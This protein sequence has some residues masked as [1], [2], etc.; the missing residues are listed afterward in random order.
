MLILQQVDNIIQFHLE[1]MENWLSN[2]FFWNA[3]SICSFYFETIS[4]NC[5]LD[6]HTWISEPSALTTKFSNRAISSLSEISLELRLNIGQKQDIKHKL[7]SLIFR[8][9]WVV[10]GLRSQTNI[11]LKYDNRLNLKNVP[12]YVILKKNINL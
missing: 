3:R 4:N 1:V 8:A 12:V 10:R 7:Q 11:S 6:I 9:A 5:F 2:F